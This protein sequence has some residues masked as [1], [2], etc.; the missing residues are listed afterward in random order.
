MAE[1]TTFIPNRLR[2]WIEARRR[3]RLPHAHVQ[4]ARELGLDPKKLGKLDNHRQEPW[5]ASLPAFIENLYFKRFGKR[6][7]DH[8]RTIEEIAAAQ[9]A[10]KQVKKSA[11]SANTAIGT[12]SLSADSASAERGSM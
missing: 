4:M 2:L 3:F 5:K 9:R 1:D 12:D 6:K 8:V 11:K 10:K 7:P